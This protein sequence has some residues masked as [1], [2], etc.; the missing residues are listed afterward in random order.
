MSSIT[1][2]KELRG[3]LR[4]ML[5]VLQS[6]RQALASLDLEAIMGCVYDKTELCDHLDGTAPAVVDQECLGMLEAARRLNEVNRQ[7]R[8][9]IAAN[10]TARLEALSGTQALYRPRPAHSPA[11]AYTGGR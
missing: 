6:E 7:I 5:A 4:K 2:P 3:A 9:L 8:N 1:S 11:Y 10:V